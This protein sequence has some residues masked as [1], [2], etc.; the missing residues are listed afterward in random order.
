MYAMRGMNLPLAVWLRWSAPR[1]RWVLFHEVAFPM[2]SEYSLKQ[3]FLGLIQHLMA[4]SVVR[5]ADRSFITVPRWQSI[6]RKCAPGCLRSEIVPV[7]SNVAPSAD[8]DAVARLCS[9]FARD[10]ADPIVGHFGT[11]G[12]AI[13][14]LVEPVVISLLEA[15]PDLVFVA[16]GRSS[17]VWRA[18]FLARHPDFADRTHATGSTSPERV[19]E[20]LSACDLLIQPYPDGASGRR[21]TAMAGIALGRPV[22]TDSGTATE[23]V[24]SD[25][26]LVVLSDASDTRAM[27]QA[28]VALLDD[29]AERTALGKRAAEGYARHFG[30]DRTLKIL[31]AEPR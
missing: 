2:S 13:T 20:Y 29:P 23:P 16:I 1:P 27:V 14:S 22:V 24:W 18:G 30:I 7:P 4:G 5:G 31:R 28:I 19:A 6:L 8:A 25:E 26:C 15:R 21:T 10:P 3:R 9:A 11:W 12:E 17:E